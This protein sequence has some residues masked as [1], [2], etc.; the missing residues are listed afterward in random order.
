MDRF[1]MLFERIKIGSVELR[2]RFV[3]AP[4]ATHLATEDGAV[5][6]RQIDYYA[7][8]AKGG[9]GL[10]ITESCCVRDDGRRKKYRLSIS[11]DKFIPG[12]MRLAGSVHNFGA[13]IAMQLHHGGRLCTPRDI[14][15]FPVS[16]SGYRG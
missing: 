9:V 1:E 5:S 8:R 4:M 11:D 13:K 3:M 10:V 12:F 14:N 15:E 6:K 7:E 2:N 16:A